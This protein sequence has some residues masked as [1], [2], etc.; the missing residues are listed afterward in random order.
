MRRAVTFLVLAFLLPLAACGDGPTAVPID[1]VGTWELR[2]INDMPLPVIVATSGEDTAEVL[3]G[4]IILQAD[5][6]FEDRVTMRFTIDGEVTTDLD[7]IE[8][9]YTQQGG[10]LVLTAGGGGTFAATV[11]DGEL[12]QIINQLTLR[13]TR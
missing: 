1:V 2:T 6:R 13:Y 12:V 11:T 4:S 5:G 7:V 8:G 10:A 9:T 3:Q